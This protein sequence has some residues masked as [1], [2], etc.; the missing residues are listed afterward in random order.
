[1]NEKMQRVYDR[2]RARYSMLLALCPEDSPLIEAMLLINVGR[3][4]WWERHRELQKPV[5]WDKE[6]PGFAHMN[7]EDPTP[8]LRFVGVAE[9]ESSGG[10]VIHGTRNHGW[11]TN[12]DGW[13]DSYG[14]GLVWGVVFQM[15]PVNRC[16]RFV[17]GYQFGGCGSG[18]TLDLKE[19]FIAE[20]PLS[21]GED[22]RECD[23]ARRAARHAD[24]LA[25]KMAE[26]ERW[27]QESM[28]D[29]DDN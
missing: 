15:R 21:H 8:L 16:P 9:L 27:Y 23:A 4:R 29:D 24:K 3:R 7:H 5:Y 22:H 14:Y 25:E 10:I 6:R 20:A 17:G 18:P 26:L 19:Q 28:D 13:A 1:M 12:N 2:L 11:F